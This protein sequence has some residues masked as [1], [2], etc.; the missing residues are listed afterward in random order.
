LQTNGDYYKIPNYY[1]VGFEK[2]I[3]LQNV[4][5]A[6]EMKVGFHDL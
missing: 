2:E 6:F 1:K 4:S 5:L 3:K